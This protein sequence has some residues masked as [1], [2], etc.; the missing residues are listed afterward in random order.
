MVPLGAY[1]TIFHSNHDNQNGII[2]CYSVNDLDSAEIVTIGDSFFKRPRRI[3]KIHTPSSTLHDGYLYYLCKTCPQPLYNLNIRKTAGTHSVSAAFQ[4]LEGNHIPKCKVLLVETVERFLV[5]RLSSARAVPMLPID[6]I[7]VNPNSPKK[8]DDKDDHFELQTIAAHTRLALNIN[9]PVKK[10][11]L[12]QPMFTHKRY[13]KTLFFYQEDLNFTNLKDADVKLAINNLLELQQ[14]AKEKGI[15]LIF[16]VASDK[17]DLYYNF[18]KDNPYPKNPTMDYFANMD[19]SW[20]LNTQQLLLPYL[21]KG[22]K[23]IYNVNDTHWSVFSDSIVA[24]RI[25]EMINTHLHSTAKA[26]KK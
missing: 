21:K 26:V 11:A 6:S 19:T 18:I 1:D 15:Y 4:L 5:G 17:Y 12:Q 22:V 14:L 7:I 13:D 9:Q 10:V 16:V 23:D 3:Y 2:E 20:F 24:N 8:I 25:A